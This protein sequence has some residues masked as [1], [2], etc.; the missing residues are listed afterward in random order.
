MVALGAAG[1]QGTSEVKKQRNLR[2]TITL[3]EKQAT[4]TKRKQEHS[5]N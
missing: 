5:D 3:T 2:S 1:T 4:I